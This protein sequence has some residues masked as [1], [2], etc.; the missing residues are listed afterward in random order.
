ME[1][2]SSLFNTLH[3]KV[4]IKGKW[5]NLEKREEASFT[6]RCSSYWKGSLLVM[7]DYSRLTYLLV[8]Y[9]QPT[10]FDML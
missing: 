4:R 2:D 10:K 9:I 5:S 6:G 3:N 1:L 8:K 7:L